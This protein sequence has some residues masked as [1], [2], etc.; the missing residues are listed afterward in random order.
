[1]FSQK[2]LRGL[3]AVGARL[4][5]CAR[6]SHRNCQ[7]LTR[8]PGTPEACGEIMGF[9]YL[10]AQKS[11]LLRMDFPLVVKPRNRTEDAGHDRTRLVH[12]VSMFS[13]TRNGNAR[14]GVGV[15]MIFLNDLNPK[16]Q[17]PKS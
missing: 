4:A 6:P 10:E 16:P 2:T 14:Y 13:G 9:F 5:G 12:V 3:T 17:N 11:W 8:N 1:M 7:N 15:S